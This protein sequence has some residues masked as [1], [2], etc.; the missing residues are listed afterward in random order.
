MNDN[1][2]YSDERMELRAKCIQLLFMNFGGVRIE[3]AP[4]STEDI[5]SA[6]HDWVSQGNPSV[7]GLQQFFETHYV[8]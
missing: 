6:S 5:Y 3:T 1:W 4:Y 2:I 7:E 8:K